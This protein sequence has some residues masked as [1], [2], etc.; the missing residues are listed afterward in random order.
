MNFTWTMDETE[1]KRLKDTQ[2]LKKYDTND[3]FGSCY[4][5]G[6]CCD[7]Q[8]TMDDSSWY[9]FVNLFYVEE[10]STY[11]KLE[12]GTRYDIHYGSP[13]LPI[14]C[15][16]FKTFK[17]KFEKLFEDYINNHDELKNL[18]EKTVIWKCIS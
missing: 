1:W 15:V 7:F 9:A 8:H 18:I 4:V 6:I 16:T 3:Y 11:G 14:R 5:G 10:N 17:K 13:I 2:R 12:D